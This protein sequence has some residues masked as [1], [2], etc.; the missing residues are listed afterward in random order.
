MNQGQS[1]FSQIIEL[2]SYKKCQTLANRYKGDYKDLTMQL[3]KE[4]NQLD[5]GDDELEK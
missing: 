3:I 1:I 4:A 2:F 5:L